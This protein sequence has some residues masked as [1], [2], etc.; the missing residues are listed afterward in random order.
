MTYPETKDLA[1]MGDFI[2][3]PPDLDAIRLGRTLLPRAIITQEKKFPDISFWQEVPDFDKMKTQTDTVILR[4][5]QNVWKDTQYDNNIA[6]ARA[7]GMYTGAYW[8]YDDRVSPQAQAAKMDEVLN[9]YTPPLGIV[10][11]WENSYGGSYG[12]LKNFVTFMKL[13]QQYYPK[14]KLW[15]YTGYYWFTGNSSSSQNPN[16]YAWLRDNTHL[17]LAWYT[18]N[19][20]NVI[21]PQPYS[22]MQMWQ[23]GT[24]AIG[25]DY[26]VSSKEIDMN[27]WNG[28]NQSF[29]DFVEGSIVEPPPV[30]P[31]PVI[32]EEEFGVVLADALNIRESNSSSSTKWGYFVKGDKLWGE[33][34]EQNEG[35]RW[36]KITSPASQAGR[37]C[38][39]GNDTISYIQ[40]GIPNQVATQVSLSGGD[41]YKKYRNYGCWINVLTTNPEGKRYLVTPFELKTLSQVAAERNPDYGTNGADFNSSGAVG[42]AVSDGNKFGS[43]VG[44]Q[45]FVNIT[46]KQQ[47]QIRKWNETNSPD[48][49]NALAGKRILVENG[50]ISSNTSDAWNEKHPRTLAG[51][52]EDGKLVQIVVDGRQYDYN[53][54]WM[55]GVDLYQA[56][57]LLIDAGCL[58]GTDLDGGGSS[59]MYI[60]E[61]GGIVNV[62]IQN[63]IIG[64]QRYVGDTLIS[65]IEDGGTPEPP[66]EGGELRRYKVLQDVR[67]RYAPNLYASYDTSD[68]NALAGEEFDSLESSPDTDP[69]AGV[70]EN[71]IWEKMPSTDGQGR[72]VPRS[73]DDGRVFLEDIGEV[74]PPPTEPQVVWNVEF[75]DDLTLWI[76]GVQYQ[77][78]AVKSVASTEE[79]KL[80]TFIM[81]VLRFIAGLFS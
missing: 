13:M 36:M 15:L 80:Y 67:K 48:V 73:L 22:K 63:D 79:D 2:E 61:L 81:K 64:N 32:G 69:I 75:K 47:P 11:D 55:E 59:V 54:V 39:I 49:Y 23:Y 29:Y 62:P 12:G 10:G 3:H 68:P 25:A 7:R 45:P 8:F 9:G 76:N 37:Y 16:E 66:P 53:G 24:P 71:T 6:Q 21:I 70:S 30:E 20:S 74:T 18:S 26:G 46:A 42:F 34:V 44:Y 4:A 78:Q 52:T 51:V 72:W 38:A 19:P 33:E 58:S 28:T 56:A 57:Q 17:W 40:F 1:K 14:A 50:K 31:P 60:K 77:E 27:W 41:T 43:Q 65:F 5:G 35:L